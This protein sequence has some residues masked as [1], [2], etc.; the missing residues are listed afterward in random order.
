[1]GENNSK[2]SNGKRINLKNIQATPAAQIQKY[3][4][5]NQKMGLFS[6]SV[7]SDSLRPHELQHTRS[8]CP[9]PN[10]E[11]TQTH[12]HRF[13]DAIQPSHPLL[14]PSPPAPNPSQRQ[15]L[16]QWLNALHI[17]EMQI[18]TTMRYHFTPIRMTVIQKSASNKCWRGCGEKGTLLHG[19][20]ECKL[21]YHYGDQLSL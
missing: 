20:W 12:I 16:F 21:V 4:R 3:K 19:W 17:R 5:P 7:M 2:R 1:M 13:S 6:C 14:S 9:S 18:K 15:S 10:L 8:P 11:F